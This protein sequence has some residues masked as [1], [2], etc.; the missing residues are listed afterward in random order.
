MTEFFRNK[1]FLVSGVT[2][3]LGKALSEK[4][5]S[6]GANVIGVSRRTTDLQV[7]HIQKCLTDITPEDLNKND[8]SGVFHVAS[9]VGMWG[10]WSDFYN[11]NVL[12]TKHLLSLAKI[13]NIPNFVY[14]S[15]PSVIAQGI[16][17]CGVD[18]S[19]PY[20]R[21]F[22]SPYPKSKSMAEREVL[23]A[24]NGKFK[25]L[26]LRPHLIFGPGDTNLLP[27]IEKKLRAGSLKKIGTGKNLVDFTY[28]DDCVSAHLCGML[29]LD[30]N[31]R[32]SGRAYFI[33][34][35]DP[36]PLWDFINRFAELKNLP[37]INNSIG[38]KKAYFIGFVLEKLSFIT[39]KEPRI[40]RFL[41]EEMA[42]HHFFNISAAKRELKFEPS[43][44]V[45]DALE[46]TLN[47]FNTNQVI[48]TDKKT[49]NT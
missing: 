35:G 6:L 31:P 1:T 43:R 41:V 37:Q 19:I 48:E 28:I 29:A 30:S 32:A 24:S 25:T 7:I 5:I 33:S 47:T 13:L 21:E 15:S 22:L 17:L 14:T 20:P 11:T 16:D 42:T 12:G 27:T 3:F 18:E 8:I 44:K 26:S 2:G 23:R 34:Q 10:N 40:N 36:V 39:K 4:L 46:S 45:F 38:F 9:K 49:A